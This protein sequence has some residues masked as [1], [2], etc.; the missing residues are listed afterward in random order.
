MAAQLTE[1][2]RDF[3]MKVEPLINVQLAR[4]AE[5]V[6]MST[7]EL[8]RLVLR[9]FLAQPREWYWREVGRQHEDKA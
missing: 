7:Q 2:P 6:G 8:A 4:R 5:A 9:D 1:L 3:N